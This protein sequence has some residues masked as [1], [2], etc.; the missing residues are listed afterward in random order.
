MMYEI[1]KGNVRH[2]FVNEMQIQSFR[3]GLHIMK[4]AGNCA[5]RHQTSQ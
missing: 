2:N 5:N 4:T 3:N 1:Q